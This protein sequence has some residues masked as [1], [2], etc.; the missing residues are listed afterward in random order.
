MKRFIFP[1]RVL[2]TILAISLVFS[3]CVRYQPKLMKSSSFLERIE[4][5]EDGNVKVS[6]VVLSDKEG[7]EVFGT[8]LAKRGVQP[9]WLK[10]ENGDSHPYL[11]LKRN[12]DP[13][14][15]SPDEAA[16]RN[17]YSL[18][19]RLLADGLISALFFPF[20]LGVP[21][22]IISINVANKKMDRAFDQLG[23]RNHL[24]MPHETVSGFMFTRV[25]EGAKHVS[26]QLLGAEQDKKFDFFVKVPGI[27]ADYMKRDFNARY[28]EK[29][30]IEC[31]DAALIKVLEALPCC[32]SNEKGDK[33]GDPINLV[34]I[35]DLEELLEAF[36][37]AKWDETQSLS[38]KSG[39]LMSQAFLFGRTD[40]YSPVSP[41]YYKGH[42]HDVA[43]QK[44]RERINERLHLRLWFTPIRYQ[45]KPVW[46]G[47]VSRDIGVKFTM[48]TW[49]LT[50]HEIDPHL[51]DSRD[52]VLEDLASAQRAERYGFVEGAGLR[53]KDKPG[54]NLM[55]SPYYTDGLRVVI[56]LSQ[57][58][59]TLSAFKWELPIPVR[60]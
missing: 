39:F 31:D 47:G 12:L 41:L 35:G 36:A 7:E 49:Y 3:G 29:D 9:I 5:Q 21:V 58:D 18:A 25:D 50:T 32:T 2:S 1:S 33:F 13:N 22:T 28:S 6:L 37:A 51:D 54:K 23:I 59:K 17:H 30:L 45:G 20:L 10:I 44:A 4:T 52:Y 15:Y 19:K 43:F 53:T 55:G 57:E 16:Y 26:V 24:V 40:K 56:E 38:L 14:Y 42:S 11:F 60:E 8:P 34:V 48:K 46:I 27:K